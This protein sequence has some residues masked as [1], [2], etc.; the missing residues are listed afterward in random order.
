MTF[1]ELCSKVKLLPHSPGVYMMKDKN[2]KVIYVGKSKS[3]RDRVSSYFLSKEKLLPKTAKLQE[4]ISDFECLYTDSET[5]ALILENE[6]IKKYSPKYNIKL[7]DAKTYPYIKIT[8]SKYPKLVLTRTRK[9]DKGKY[10]GPYTSASAAKEIIKTAE[11]I[12]KIASCGKDFEYGRKICRP[13]LNYHINQCTAPCSGDIPE[14]AYKNQFA[15]LES[16][17]KGNF[18]S[19]AE[20][21]RIKMESESENLNFENAA[22]YRDALKAL[23]NLCENQKIISD[24]SADFDVFGLYEAEPLCAISIIFIRY[25]KV[26][27]KEQI[28]FSSNELSDEHALSDLIQRYYNSIGYIPK[29]IILSF[30]LPEEK[31]ESIEDFLE[32]KQ[33]HKTKIYIPKTGRKKELANMASENAKEYAV[34]YLKDTNRS[35][36][37]LMKL[38]ELLR[39]DYIPSRIEAYDISNNGNNNIYAGMIVL[40]DGKFKKSHYR[41]FSVKTVSGADDYAS[42]REV[43]DRRLKRYSDAANGMEGQNDESFS[44]LPDIILLDGGVGHV[45]AVKPVIG[46]YDLP[47]DCFGMVK[48]SFHKTRTLTDGT[49]EISI[50]KK[51]DIYSF[52]YKIQEEVHRFTFSKMDSSRRKTVTS[53]GLEKING[54]G[55]SK[56]VI[57][58]KQFKNIQNIKKASTEELSKV[59]GISKKDAENIYNFYNKSKENI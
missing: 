33:G 28:L 43:V 49:N 14:S 8:N 18:K 50:A 31:I 2:G 13:C 40:E 26:I 25:G 39:L 44:A 57:L 51:Q 16:F 21:L 23:Q 46:K 32:K 29:N 59:K 1:L 22:R 34:Q 4:N 37:T 45:N 15:E 38:S 41:T 52:I 27:D 53:S 7:K 20:S 3:L 42:M 47:V 36:Q 17:L 5:E 10:F 58:L 35:L 9:N 56:S 30:G 48:D 19:V 12:F 24:A 6:L 11:K 55:K 54:I